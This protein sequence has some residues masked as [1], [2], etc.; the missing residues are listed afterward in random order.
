V[1]GSRDLGEERGSSIIY[2]Y[3][4]IQDTEYELVNVDDTGNTAPY[5]GIYANYC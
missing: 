3:Q 5:L 4:E 1:D 2:D